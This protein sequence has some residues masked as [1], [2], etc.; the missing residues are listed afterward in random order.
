MN[1]EGFTKNFITVIVIQAFFFI[2]YQ[3]S[4]QLPYKLPIKKHVFSHN[5]IKQ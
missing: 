4:L 2:K 5:S 3:K 1:T